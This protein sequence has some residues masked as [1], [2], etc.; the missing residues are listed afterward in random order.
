MRCDINIYRVILLTCTFSELELYQKHA[1]SQDDRPPPAATYL[2]TGEKIPKRSRVEDDDH[3]AVDAEYGGEESQDMGSDTDED[4]TVPEVSVIL[5]S[6]SEL[7]GM[8]LFSLL[9]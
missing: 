8:Q 3:M 9:W 1:V 6:E 4:V 5:V 2:I 7:K